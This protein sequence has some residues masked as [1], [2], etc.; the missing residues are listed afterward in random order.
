MRIA[1]ISDVHGTLPAPAAM[2]TA[3]VARALRTGRN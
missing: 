3:G 1:V 2:A